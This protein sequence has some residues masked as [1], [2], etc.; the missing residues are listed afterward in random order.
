MYILTLV[1]TFYAVFR[2]GI[3]SMPQLVILVIAAVLALWHVRHAAL[4]A[5]IW[6]AFM[7]GYLQRTPLGAGPGRMAALALPLG[8]HV[9]PRWSGRFCLGRSGSSLDCAAASHA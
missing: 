8:G 6:M 1:L 7:P 4:Y 9:C 3:R 2:L 5:M